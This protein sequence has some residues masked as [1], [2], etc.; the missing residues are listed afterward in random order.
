MCGIAGIIHIDHGQVSAARVKKMT[1]TLAHRG[2]DGERQWISADGCT[3]LGHRRLSI[4]DLS[5]QASQP[6]HYAGRYTIIFNGEIYNYIELKEMLTK[7][8][9]AFATSSDTEVIMALY[10]AEKENCLQMLDGMFAFVIYDEKEK[11]VFCARD[12]FGEKPF[13]YLH[14]KNEYFIFASEIKA[15]IALTGEQSI[16]N[17]MLYNYLSSGYLSNIADPSETFYRDILKLPQAHYLN[18]NTRDISINIKEYWKIDPTRIDLSISPSDAIE[19]FRQ[20]LYTSVNRRLRSDVN[21]G[22][23]LSGGIDSSVIVGIIDDLLKKNKAEHSFASSAFKQKTFSARFPGFE[24]DEGKYMQMVIDRTN[25]E[26]HFIYPSEETLLDD[27]DKVAYYQDEPF[28][29]A[30]ILVQYEVMRLA[31]Q[32]DVTVLLDGQGADEILAGYHW[33]FGIFFREL[34]KKNK[35]ALLVA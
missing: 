30:S 11:N 27:I 1:D 25:V 8:G 17:K 16:N 12:R 18:V 10:D 9:Y 5:E 14:K 21:V 15:L 23:S 4:I 31:K 7:K 33:Y 26:P 6:M 28:G 34:E 29:G 19:N 13:F 20:L 24:R 2:P 22:S 3:G 32:N 35:G